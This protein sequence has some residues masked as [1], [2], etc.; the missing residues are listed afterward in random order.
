MVIAIVVLMVWVVFFGGDGQGYFEGHPDSP[1]PFAFGFGFGGS[2]GVRTL[3]GF[4]E[5]GHK[6]H[7]WIYPKPDVLLTYY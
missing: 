1:V 2:D 4:T 6:M 7:H 5:P 3:V